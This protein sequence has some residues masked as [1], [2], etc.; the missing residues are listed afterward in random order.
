MG[1]RV[2]LKTR[3]PFHVLEVAILHGWHH[4]SKGLVG[5]V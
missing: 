5:L 2:V 4:L 1:F 3:E